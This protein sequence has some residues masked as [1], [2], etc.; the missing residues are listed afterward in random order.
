MTCGRKVLAEPAR[1]AASNFFS[2]WNNNALSDPRIQLIIQDAR[3][4]LQLT[5]QSYDVT[6]SEP[7]NPWMAGLAALFTRDFP[8]YA[9]AHNAQGV[10]LIR[11]G[12]LDEA[13]HHFDMALRLNPDF[14]GTHNNMGIALARN[15]KMEDAA[16]HFKEA[17]R[18][19][20]DFVGARNN[21]NKIL[22][23]R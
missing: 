19:N 17:L 9:D 18:L 7:S 6:I 10:A 5:A 20:P 23:R 12:R 4:H 21:L 16:G 3:A 2:P 8:E 1:P 13:T 22:A 15:G 11:Q 14:A